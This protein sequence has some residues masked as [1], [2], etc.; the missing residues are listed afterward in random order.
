MLTT[1]NVPATAPLLP[2]NLSGGFSFI[3]ETMKDCHTLAL[4]KLNRWVPQ[5]SSHWTGSRRWVRGTDR[6]T[7]SG[8][9][10]EAMVP[11]I[12][13]TESLCAL[14]KSRKK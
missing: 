2:K 8:E 13:R 6:S 9:D 10:S 14:A 7:L 1:V 4:V 11:V 3:Q 5:C 12:G